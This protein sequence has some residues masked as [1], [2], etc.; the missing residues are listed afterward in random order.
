[1]GR[2]PL[3]TA[4]FFPA[5]EFELIKILGRITFVEIVGT[6]SVEMPP[7][8]EKKTL[9]GVIEEKLWEGEVIVLC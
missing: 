6:T 7:I 9:G 3:G 1:M 2:E 4:L 5:N 8:E